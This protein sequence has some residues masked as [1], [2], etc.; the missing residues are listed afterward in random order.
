MTKLIRFLKPFKISVAVVLLLVFAQTF[1]ELY[2]PTLMADIVDT[3]IVN[4]NIPYIINTGGFML[5]I[6][7]AGT[8]C[9][10]GASFLASKTAA[11]LGRL[12]RSKVFSRVEDF[13]LQ[14]FNQMGTATLI[15]RTTNDI[16]QIQTVT[17]MILRMMV[18]AP[19]MC[20]GGIFMAVSMDRPL[21]LLLLIAVPLIVLL[22]T[23]IM[24]HAIPLFKLMQ[25]KL[26]RL[27]LVLRENLTG[28][29][30]IRAFNRISRERERFTAANRDLTDNAI[31]VNKLMAAMMPGMML[32][33][34]FTIIAIIWFGSIRI[35]GGGMQVGSL[36]AFIQYATM[37]LLSLVMMS[38]MFI[39][40]PRA[41]AS[42]VRIN[43]I[44]DI[45]PGIKDPDRVKQPDSDKGCLEFKDVSF[46]FPG[47]EQPA[48]SNISF[49]ARP[50]ETTAI[51]GGTGSGKTTLINLIP[52][53]YDVSQGAVLIDGV[54]VREMSQESLR[55]KIGL[56]PQTAVLFSGS[57][58][59]NIR[60]GQ[61]DASPDE[62]Y[63]AAQTA[64]ALEF[65]TG[66]KNGFDSFIEQGGA[67]VS[68]GQKQRLSIARAIVRRPDIYIFDDSFS[69]LDFKTDA[70]LRAALK[71]ETRESTVLII[72]QRVSTIMEAD[73]IIVLENGQIAGKG[74]HEELL[75][76]CEV[77]REI[78]YLQLSEEELA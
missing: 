19:I 45:I 54:D 2:L 22:V 65:I 66:M 43:E 63:A 23:F 34:N 70:R 4:G 64:Q 52:R 12:L 27:N 68:G 37:I 28:I 71:E 11:G 39:M 18:S 46:S 42:A 50:G 53:F 56:V 21:S 73:Q 29:R 32:V 5:L 62:V 67:N 60:V 44:L 78:V 74:S 9:S 26:D 49:T 36:M 76:S 33:M 20:L 72:A 51:I 31:R 38:M 40:L 55:S 47:A 35:D 57:I 69:A 17:F 10:I 77:Y 41:A 6:A 16:N 75:E 24:R 25:I 1:S 58:T 13:S 48:L 3:G 30:V 8:L 59:E 14:E 7:A 61:E 15:T